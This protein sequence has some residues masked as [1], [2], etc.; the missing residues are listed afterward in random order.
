[1][2]ISHYIEGMPIDNSARGIDFP[3][4]TTGEEQNQV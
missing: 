2:K 1:M 3:R 4:K